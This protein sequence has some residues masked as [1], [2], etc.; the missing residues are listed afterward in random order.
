M[1]YDQLHLWKG[2]LMFYFVMVVILLW[3]FS[4][5]SSRWWWDEKLD[6][7]ILER[8]LMVIFVCLIFGAVAGFLS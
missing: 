7:I 6:D 8:Y 2:V 1:C 4:V 3:S 5:L